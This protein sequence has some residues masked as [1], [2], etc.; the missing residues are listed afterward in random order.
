MET[1][2]LVGDGFVD[3]P[4]NDDDNIPIIVSYFNA[5][6]QKS[7]KKQ[8][9]NF[10]TCIWMYIDVVSLKQCLYELPHYASMF[11]CL[12]VLMTSLVM[13]ECLNVFYVNNIIYWVWGIESDVRGMRGHMSFHLHVVGPIQ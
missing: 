7:K 13:H 11:L 8:M 1:Q 3:I 9:Y 2:T 12:Y 4:P 6:K 5:K 10:M